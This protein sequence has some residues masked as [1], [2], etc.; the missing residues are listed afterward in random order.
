MATTEASE[1]Q[2]RLDELEA[3]N[4]ELRKKLERYV[5][6]PEGLPGS[7]VLLVFFGLIALSMALAAG[8][9]VSGRKTAKER[10]LR[11]TAV[12]APERV[13][14]AGWAL[15]RGLHGCLAEV[16]ADEAVDVRLEARLTPSGTVGL[17]EATARPNNERFVPCVRRVPAGVKVAAEPEASAGKQAPKLEVRYLIEQTQEGTYQSRWSWR[18]LP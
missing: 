8:L 18:P 10:A 11:A 5:P 3:Q 15:V 1:L 2:A 17:I 13:D 7:R 14:E 12:A 4:A 6:P 16:R 9:W